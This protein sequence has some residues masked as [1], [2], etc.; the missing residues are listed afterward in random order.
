MAKTETTAA[1]GSAS[2][3]EQKKFPEPIAVF[4][5]EKRMNKAG[6]KRRYEGYVT[7]NDKHYKVVG[8]PRKHG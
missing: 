2:T 3:T 6:D 4:N 7:I 1:N 8:F 5:M